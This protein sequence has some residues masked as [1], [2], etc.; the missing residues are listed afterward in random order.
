VDIFPIMTQ[1]HHMKMRM[2]SLVTAFLLPLGFV[3]PSAINAAPNTTT[4]ITL[5]QVKAK[6]TAT[7]CWSIVNGKVY[8]LT[9][10]V[11]KHPGGSSRIIGMCG[12]DAS[13]TFNGQHAGQGSPESNLAMYQIGIVKK[14]KR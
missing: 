7:N 9:D 10:W 12:K 14:K 6:N 3:A 13:R 1:T 4:Q 2:F 5:K 11:S 8:N